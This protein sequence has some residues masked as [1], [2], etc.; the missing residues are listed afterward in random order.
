MIDEKAIRERFWPK[1][2]KT[3]GCWIWNAGKTSRDLSRGYG[4]FWLNGRKVLSH[5][6]SWEI[7]NGPIPKGMNVLH[8]CDNP[9]CV[10]PEHLWLGT[11]SDNIQDAAD[12]GL[13]THVG[14]ARLTHCPSGHPYIDTDRNCRGHRECKTCLKIRRK[15]FYAKQKV[16]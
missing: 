13:L 7:H 6:V 3:L 10:N 15:R 2:Y 14:K 12:K 8:D 9:P 1:V 4:I 16:A 11:H 5:R